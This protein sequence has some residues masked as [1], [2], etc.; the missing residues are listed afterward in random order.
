MLEELNLPHL[1]ALSEK[2]IVHQSTISKL[3]QG[4][5]VELRTK[6]KVQKSIERISLNWLITGEGEKYLEEKRQPGQ[7]LNELLSQNAPV[8][9]LNEI[10]PLLRTIGEN[11]GRLVELQSGHQDGPRYEA[12]ELHLTIP[13]PPDHLSEQRIMQYD[14]NAGL[15]LRWARTE[16][17]QAAFPDGVPDHALE[18]FC[19]KVSGFYGGGWIDDISGMLKDLIE[20][21]NQE[22][23]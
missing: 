8:V 19:E 7:L 20:E 5:N 3:L 16:K 18:E 13:D 10:L 4:S 23:R 21:L 9:L 14:R 12:T 1:K 11:T 22:K 2:A 17:A 15:L 6:M